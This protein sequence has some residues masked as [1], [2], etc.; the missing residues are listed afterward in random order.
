MNTLLLLKC[1]T[2]LSRECLVNGSND[3]RRGAESSFLVAATF[4]AEGRRARRVIQRNSE[5][6]QIQASPTANLR[7]VVRG[8]STITKNTPP[9]QH[10]DFRNYSFHTSSFFIHLYRKPTRARSLHSRR[11]VFCPPYGFVKS[12]RSGQ[13]HYHNAKAPLRLQATS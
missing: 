7:P 8:L 4:V 5:F 12:H 9:E 1:A 13:M 6:H 11:L 10:S 3:Y 2:A